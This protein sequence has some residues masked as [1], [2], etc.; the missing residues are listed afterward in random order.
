MGVKWCFDSAIDGLDGLQE[1]RRR[2][3]CRFDELVA[4]GV[5]Y[6]D[7]GLSK[8]DKTSNK[9]RLKREIFETQAIV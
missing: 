4:I 6:G 7:L 8:A 1:W 3:A 9:I 2:G 5:L